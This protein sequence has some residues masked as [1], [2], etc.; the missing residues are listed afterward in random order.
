MLVT[1]HP[2]FRRFWYPVVPIAQIQHGPAA[3]EL[4]GQRLV[5]WQA[6]E[7]Q[8]VAVADRCC[9]RSA[10]LSQ[11]TVVDG[12]IQCP[13]HGWCFDGQGRCVQVPQVP[14]RPISPAYQVPGYACVERYGYAWVC[15]DSPLADIPDIPEAVDPQFR[16][17]P[18]FYEP[19]RCAGLRLMENS[20]D[21]AHPHFVHHK[22][23]GISQEPVP[24][25]PTSLE[26]TDGGL[27]MT[28]GLPVKNSDMQKQNLGMESDRTLRLSRATWYAPFLRT[29][30]IT[31][32]NGLVH[33]IF[34]AATPVNDQVS[35]IV[36]FCLR[37][38]TEADA[39]AQDIIAFDRAVTLED[40]DILE[41]TDYDVPLDLHAE[42]HMWTDQPGIIMR[43]K[44]ARLIHPA[45]APAIALSSATL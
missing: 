22:T 4:L 6:A 37:N 15:L 9:H 39:P 31:Y 36:Q 20:F 28:Y 18:Q 26:E 8:S 5:I 44:L 13:Y 17:I 40:K 3:F 45:A 24:P 2:V 32:P 27:T 10:R 21:N 30:R 33:L 23:F 14:D 25:P 38:D 42:Q 1:Q 19:W 16:Y 41:G 43:R 34:T 35:Q 12:A 11:G 29:L 7:G